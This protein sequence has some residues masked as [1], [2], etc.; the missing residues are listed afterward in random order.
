MQPCPPCL[1]FTAFY[2]FSPTVFYHG[3][4]PS[5]LLY[6][7]GQSSG[8]PAKYRQALD[9][10]YI[11]LFFLTVLFIIYS[12]GG[13][14]LAGPE[15]WHSLYCIC[16]PPFSSNSASVTGAGIRSRCHLTVCSLLSWTVFCRLAFSLPPQG[17]RRA[18]PYLLLAFSMPIHQPL[19]L[20]LLGVNQNSAMNCRAPVYL[21]FKSRNNASILICA[22]PH[23]SYKSTA[24]ENLSDLSSH[25]KRENVEHLGKISAFVF[26]NTDVSQLCC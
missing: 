15:A 20:S 7:W 23:I 1:C 8:H 6:S 26:E 19:L 3:P 21:S 18:P 11:S 25:F 12:W 17:I 13:V 16:W 22:N 10:S 2:L 14:L 4:L 24:S 5:F 9:L